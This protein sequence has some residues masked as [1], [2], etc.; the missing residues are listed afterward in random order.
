MSSR[1]T[2]PT[3]SQMCPRQLE[4]NKA[5]SYLIINYLRLLLLSK[6]QHHSPS[7]LYQKSPSAS[8]L[9]ANQLLTPHFF[10]HLHTLISTASTLVRHPLQLNFETSWPKSHLFAS[11]ERIDSSLLWDP[12]VYCT[13]LYYFT[14]QGFVFICRNY[15]I[16]RHWKSDCWMNKWTNEQLILAGRNRM[17]LSLF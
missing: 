10:Y 4:L 3:A 8:P 2:D 5:Q 13:Y 7:C 6:Q 15:L 16:Q 1:S 9:M 11:L 17:K 14:Y 12:T